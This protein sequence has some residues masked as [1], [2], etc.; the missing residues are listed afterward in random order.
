MNVVVRPSV[1][2]R[3]TAGEKKTECAEPA[4]RQVSGEIHASRAQI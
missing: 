4:A 1:T 2:A 3:K